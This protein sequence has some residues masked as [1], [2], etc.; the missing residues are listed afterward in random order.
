MSTQ[1]GP[2]AGGRTGSR[3]FATRVLD[4]G[5]RRQRA[6]IAVVLGLIAVPVGVGLGIPHL[7]AG[8][9]FTTIA[10]LMILVGG[11]VLICA[12]GALLVRLTRGWRRVLVVPALLATLV[13]SL[14][15]LGQAVAATNV[16]RTELGELSPA[17]FGLTFSDA[18]FRTTD[19]V[20]LSG[21]YL[22]SENSAAVVLLH[23]AGSTRSDVLAHAVVLAGHGYGVLLFDARGHG[24]SGGRAMDFGWYGDED[25]AAAVSFLQARPE[26][27]DSRIAAVGVSMGGEEAIGAAA[28]DQ[29]IRAVVAEGATG[30]VAGD[31]AWL[32]EQFGWRGTLQ[33]GLES[34]TYGITDLLT[35]AEPPIALRAAVAASGRPVLLIAGGAEPDEPKAA[36][37][38]Q[39]A[40]P[41]T[42][43]VWVVPNAGHGAALTTNP[44]EWTDHTIDFLTTALQPR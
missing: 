44:A 36:R 1:L 6:V 39:S 18:R 16:P 27:D 21:W 43:R 15:S 26:V 17:D 5:N 41:T 14:Y 3:T 37:Y 20:L 42:V 29:R 35:A 22:P 2:E 30:R 13:V 40:A 12:G 8:V 10:G 4:R 11:L 38:I 7:K 33:E 25:I 28:G 31:K 23:G 34:L 24:R 19:D 32:S 9:G